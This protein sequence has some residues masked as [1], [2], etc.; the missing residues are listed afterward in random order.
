MK[1]YFCFLICALLLLSGCGTD[2]GTDKDPNMGKPVFDTEKDII[3]VEFYTTVD[4]IGAIE[5]SEEQL[6]ETVEWLGTFVIARAAGDTWVPGGYYTEVTIYYTDG[7]TY[8]SDLHNIVIDGA[9]YYTSSGEAPE[10]W[11]ELFG[12]EDS[13]DE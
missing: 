7:T 13:G 3:D 12:W 5:I 2:Y 9:K 1:R 10:F 11:R 4:D 6:A 8:E